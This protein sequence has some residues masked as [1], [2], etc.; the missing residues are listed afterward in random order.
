VA[1][2]GWWERLL[3]PERRPS[4][5]DRLALTGLS[6]ASILYGGASAAHR[7]L[8][9]LRG[10]W[11]P[12]VPTLCV[13]NITVGG[14]G[15]TTAARFLARGLLARGLRV[16]VILRGYGRSG[17]PVQAV[18]HDGAHPL[19]TAADVGDE[20]AMLGE[21]LGSAVVLVGPSRVLSARRAVEEFGAQVLVLDDGLQHWAIR[22]HVRIALWDA[23]QDLGQ[24]RLFPRGR[25]R[26]P[27]A[28]LAAM[29]LLILTRYDVARRP[30]EVLQ[31]LSRLRDGGEVVCA[32][33]RPTLLAR[34]DGAHEDPDCLRG[35]RVYAVSSLGNPR[36]FRL[37]L[38]LLGAEVVG[39]R[40]FA[41][42]HL[43]TAPELAEVL[44]SADR[45][46]AERVVATEKD[47]VKLRG[48][49]GAERLEALIVDL[50]ILDPPSGAGMA[51]L[52]R[53]LDG[54]LPSRRRT[55]EA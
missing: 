37:T 32:R 40:V 5:G 13:G 33:H 41:D 11:Q 8:A 1:E 21:S 31:E 29:D 14:T 42:H 34:G 53:V 44:A 28:T 43:T 49:P 15:K 54:A 3:D 10:A 45:L 46:G 18:A 36:A 50:E 51:A 7:S 24:A 38:E 22:P 48:L 25:L 52:A 47:M 19:A 35:R 2:A 20:A 26:E 30:E 55:D 17:A 12:P 16:A 39:E 9:R 23:T 27:L 6:A 4:P